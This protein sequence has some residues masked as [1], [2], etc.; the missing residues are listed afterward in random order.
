[1]LKTRPALASSEAILRRENYR[2]P[3]QWVPLVIALSL[4]PPTLTPFDFS[5][6]CGRSFEFECGNRF[7]KHGCQKRNKI[8]QNLAKDELETLERL[9]FHVSTISKWFYSSFSINSERLEL[10]L[11]R[12]HPPQVFFQ[13]ILPEKGFLAATTYE[14]ATFMLFYVSKKMRISQHQQIH[15]LIVTGKKNQN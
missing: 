2:Q 11:M 15:K 9:T 5:A 1:M 4:G 12:M 7:P 3:Y 14:F 13:C 6:M 8:S 10:K